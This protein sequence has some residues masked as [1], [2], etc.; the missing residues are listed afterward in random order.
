MSLW[1][2]AILVLVCA[3]AGLASVR[4]RGR[5]IA[6]SLAAVSLVAAAVSLGQLAASVFGVAQP[7]PALALAFLVLTTAGGGLLFGEVGHLARAH[8]GATALGLLTVASGVGVTAY[9]LAA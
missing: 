4:V 1:T 9:A 2:L 6:L 3:V 8:S 7:D 5:R